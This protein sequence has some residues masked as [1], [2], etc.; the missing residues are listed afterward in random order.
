MNSQVSKLISCLNIGLTD[1]TVVTGSAQALKYFHERLVVLLA[2]EPI[3][4][5][6]LDLTANEYRVCGVDDNEDIKLVIVWGLEY[7]LPFENRTYALRTM[8]DTGKHQGL[9]SVIFCEENH[10]MSHFT[11][12]DAPFY[13]FCLRTPVGAE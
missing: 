7:F 12:H 2:S 13:Q 1:S 8:L 6:Y 4:A 3:Q 9:K 10:Y 5:G 11:D